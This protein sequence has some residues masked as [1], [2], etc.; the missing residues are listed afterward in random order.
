MQSRDFDKMTSGGS[1][2]SESSVILSLQ[3]LWLES[4]YHYFNHMKNRLLHEFI[5]VSKIGYGTLVR[6]H[7][8]PCKSPVP[9]FLALFKTMVEGGILWVDVVGLK[10]GPRA[11]RNMG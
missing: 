11:Q 6:L 7:I 10:A 3:L 8:Y 5:A 9:S 2:W 1:F 4:M